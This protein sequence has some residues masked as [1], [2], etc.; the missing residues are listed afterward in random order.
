MIP[1]GN[2]M[3]K[4]EDL[5]KKKLGENKG[6]VVQVVLFNNYRYRGKVL[7]FD[8]NWLE[9]LDIK[10]DKLFLFSFKD[11]KNLEVLE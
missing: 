4:M 10:T 11:I 7:N 6:K 2:L 3:K 5:M 9:I 1:F 8:D